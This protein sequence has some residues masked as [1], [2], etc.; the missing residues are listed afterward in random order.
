MISFVFN[1][2]V[3][4]CS[5]L[6]PVIMLVTSS[7]SLSVFTVGLQWLEAGIVSSQDSWESNAPAKVPSLIK[8]HLSSHSYC[9][10]RVTKS[11]S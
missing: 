2:S 8:K 5:T 7:N 6:V 1:L 4:T 3:H 9:D 10:Y 11:V